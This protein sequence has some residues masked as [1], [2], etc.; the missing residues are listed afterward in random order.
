MLEIPSFVLYY[1]QNVY[2]LGGH[3][4]RV[5]GRN[6]DLGYSLDSR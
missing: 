3:T 1:G 6:R 4:L 5:K 2:K